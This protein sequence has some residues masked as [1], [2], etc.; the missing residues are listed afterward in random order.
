MAIPVLYWMLECTGCGG[1]RVVHDSYLQFV[2]T[3]DPNPAPGDGY[4]GPE[5]P[6]RYPCAS[7]CGQAMKVIASR[8]DPD[9]PDMWLHDP[10]V[11][12]WLTEEQFNEWRALILAAGF[13]VGGTYKAPVLRPWWR[14][15]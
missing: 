4:E 12:V 14:R 1:R 6:E 8:F 3:D 11:R 13:P 15:W 9:D 2:G 10:H 7:G 5:L